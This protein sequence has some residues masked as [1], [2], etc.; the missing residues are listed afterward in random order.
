MTAPRPSR[1]ASIIFSSGLGTMLEYYDFFVYVTLTATFAKTLLSHDRSGSCCNAWGGWFRRGV[2]RSPGRYAYLFSPMADR[3]GRKKTFI[4]TLTLMGVATVAMGC[5]PAYASI[6][7]W[8]PSALLVLR[9]VQGIALGG[10]VQLG[11]GVCDG[12]CATGANEASIP[13]CYKGQPAW[14]CWLP[15]RSL[16]LSRSPSMR[17][18]STAGAGVSRS[19]SRRRSWL[20]QPSFA[21]A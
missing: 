6:G 9:I 19:L 17:P 13:A 1:M 2:S 8:A 4:V 3:V 18:H 5:L 11:G 21:C 16:P 14:D 7:L 10:R 15:W 20:L 12:A